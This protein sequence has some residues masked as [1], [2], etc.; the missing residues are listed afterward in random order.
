MWKGFLVITFPNLNGLGWNLENK[1]GTKCALAQKFRGNHPRN[2]AEWSRVFSVFKC[3]FLSPIQ[4]GLSDTYPAISR[5]GF[6]VIT[7]PNLNGFGW[8]HVQN[9]RRESVCLSVHLRE[10]SEF[11][12]TGFASPKKRPQKWYFGQGAWYQHTGQTAQFWATGS[13]RGL[14]NISRK[15]HL[16]TSLK[17]RCTVWGYNS[18]NKGNF[19]PN[20]FYSAMLCMHGTSHGPVSVCVCHKSE[21]Y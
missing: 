14:V 17:G 19:V 16:C 3:V 1:S 9:N 2:S 12:C 18:P 11:L 5:K 20:H 21:F 15:C 7:S 13:F 8:N 6:S 10:M 4:R